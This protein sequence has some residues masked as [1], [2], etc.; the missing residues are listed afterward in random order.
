M[1]GAMNI[2]AGGAAAAYQAQEWSKEGEPGPCVQQQAMRQEPHA[3][4]QIG[5]CKVSS[6]E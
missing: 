6:E 3:S 4:F 2:T 5:T 1:L